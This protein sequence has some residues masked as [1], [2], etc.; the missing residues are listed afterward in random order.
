LA[1]WEESV[2]W[3]DNVTT[4]TGGEAVPGRGKGRDDASWANVNLTEPKNKENPQG[5]FSWYKWMVKR[6]KTTMN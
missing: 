3:R 6:F 1:Q 4:L 2:I 5:R